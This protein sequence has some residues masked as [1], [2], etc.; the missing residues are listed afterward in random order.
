MLFTKHNSSVGK[1]YVRRSMAS[2]KM[3]FPETVIFVQHFLGSVKVF[4]CGWTICCSMYTCACVLNLISPTF[5]W[6]SDQ[7]WTF[8]RETIHSV[9]WCHV[10]IQNHN[11]MKK[12]HPAHL[13]SRFCPVGSIENP[14]CERMQCLK[15]WKCVCMYMC[16]CLE[17][18]SVLICC[19]WHWKNL[20]LKAA[21]EFI[22]CS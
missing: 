12:S 19:F 15:V 6:M 3:C 20:A 1:N 22:W 16:M 10:T 5:I 18:E 11:E 8:L 14:L 7:C 9:K 17:R 4:F 2:S 21:E 13:T